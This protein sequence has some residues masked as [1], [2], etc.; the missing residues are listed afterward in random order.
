MDIFG[1]TYSTVGKQENFTVEKLN[2]MLEKLG[3]PPPKTLVWYSKHLKPD[4]GY[5]IDMRKLGFNPFIGMPPCDI[6]FIVGKN[7]AD[8]MIKQGIEIQ[9]YKGDEENE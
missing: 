1:G 7:M 8:E 6:C 4:D 2:E 3:P 9:N 5:K